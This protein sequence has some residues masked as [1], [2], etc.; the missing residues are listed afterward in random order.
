M[1]VKIT[2]VSITDQQIRD[3]RSSPDCDYTTNL[4]CRVA[5]GQVTRNGNPL[6][7]EIV[8]EAR[9]DCADELNRRS[10]DPLAALR[11]LVAALDENEAGMPVE[12]DED[13]AA[14][15]VRSDRRV[16]TAR[17]RSAEILSARSVK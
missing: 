16:K 14:W 12:S 17:A 6:S 5:L 9:Q 15:F 1:H 13:A 8:N 4:M 2:A 7:A 10:E 11:E 3:L